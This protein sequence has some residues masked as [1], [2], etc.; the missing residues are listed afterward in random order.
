MKARIVLVGV[1][2]LAS[3]LRARQQQNPTPRGKLGRF[4]GYLEGARF[5]LDSRS[6]DGSW[7]K[8]PV[9]T[10]FA[11][12]FLRRATRPLVASVEKKQDQEAK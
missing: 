5:L 12:L 6:N 9:D 1:V 7:N 2:L 11:I 4:D 3:S 8:K 10:C